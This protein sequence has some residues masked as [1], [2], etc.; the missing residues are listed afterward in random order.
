MGSDCVRRYVAFDPNRSLRRGYASIMRL[1][2]DHGAVAGLTEDS[3][4]FSNSFQV[5]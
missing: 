3:V 2:G 5:L 1:F 4:R